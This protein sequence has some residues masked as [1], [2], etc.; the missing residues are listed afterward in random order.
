MLDNV[1]EYMRGEYVD[2]DP[3]DLRVPYTSD[4]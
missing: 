1:I 3:V 4:F 2:D